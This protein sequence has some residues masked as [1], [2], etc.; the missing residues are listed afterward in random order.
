M[1]SV[2]DWNHIGE[3]FIYHDTRADNGQGRNRILA[4]GDNEIIYVW[5]WKSGA[6]VPYMEWAKAA[7]LG[8]HDPSI[9]DVRE[10]DD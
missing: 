10:V 2:Q 7:D 5:N 3:P 4:K 1:R 9:A 6:W 8:L